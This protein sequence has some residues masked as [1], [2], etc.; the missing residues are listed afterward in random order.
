MKTLEEIFSESER[1]VDAR[2]SDMR[3]NERRITVLSV[4]KM[5]VELEV[6]AAKMLDLENLKKLVL[7]R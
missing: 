5:K 3:P 4:A 2:F 6:A 7:P 1:F